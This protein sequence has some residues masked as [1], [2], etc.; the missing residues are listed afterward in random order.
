MKSMRDKNFLICFFIIIASLFVFLLP[1]SVRADISEDFE[2]YELGYPLTSYG[3]VGSDSYVVD[4]KNV[5][6]GFQN[7]GFSP[8]EESKGSKILPLLKTIPSYLLLSSGQY[9]NWTLPETFETCK[10]SIDVFTDDDTLENFNEIYIL[11]PTSSYNLAYFYFYPDGTISGYHLNGDVLIGTWTYGNHYL[12]DVEYDG[13]NARYR[14]NAGDWT[15]WGEVL[16][17]NYSCGAVNFYT[18][19][20]YPF[21]YWF[22]DIQISLSPDV[23]PATSDETFVLIHNST[24]GAEFYLDK[25]I[26]YGEL[27][28][29]IFL[30]IFLIFFIFNFIWNF[31]WSRF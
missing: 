23:V 5:Y 29:I 1:G 26:D 9:I 10:F 17:K 15:A 7:M 22:D 16:N 25:K 2:T 28:I 11:D 6:S 12:I 8:L 13:S 20:N 19:L 3:W 18:S 31:I 27:L 4:N 30:S 21:S 14:V 24:T